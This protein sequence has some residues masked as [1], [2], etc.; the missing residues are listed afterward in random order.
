M[1][2]Q[3]TQAQMLAECRRA[4]GLEVTDS[5]VSVEAFEG[6]DVDGMLGQWLDTA[7]LRLLDTAPPEHL[8][9]V[10]L[11]AQVTAQACGQLWQVALPLGVRRVTWVR[12]DGWQRGL[13]PAGV[14]QAGDR[15]LAMAS[16][17][18]QPS[19]YEPVALMRRGRLLVAPGNALP[20]L[21]IE[22]VAEPAPGTYAL[23][24]V[25]WPQLLAM[26]AEGLH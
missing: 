21:E 6:T 14:D 5:G 11:T 22:A 8:P 3:Y 18:L 7:Y 20:L 26:V 17:Y 15:L 9:S 23:D 12:L 24:P 25:L 19:A 2:V 16:P 13:V 4:F 10:S 1:I